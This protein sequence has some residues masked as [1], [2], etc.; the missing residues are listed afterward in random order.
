MSEDGGPND[1]RRMA[2]KVCIG[3]L[4]AASAAMVS[5]PVV[6]FLGQPVRVGMDKPVEVPLDKLA[7]GQAQYADLRG[8][9]IIVLVTEQGPKVLNA[10]CPHLGC[11]V[12]WNTSD[13]TFHCPCHGAVFDASGEVVSGPVSSPLKS[14]DFEIKDGKVV[15]A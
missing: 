3:G 14:L 10:S 12:I 15:V 4:A 5:Y 9:Q 1:G 7:V 2:C 13:S 6:S 8:Q 11:N